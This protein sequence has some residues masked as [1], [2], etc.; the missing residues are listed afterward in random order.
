[1]TSEQDHYIKQFESEVRKR[2]E[3]PDLNWKESNS[4]ESRGALF[5]DFQGVTLMVYPSNGLISIPAVRTYHPPKYPTPVIA[6]ASAKDLW[7]R[8]K[9][10][11]DGN[12]DLARSRTTGHLGPIVD[13]DL[14]CRNPKCPCQDE[15]PQARKGRARGGLNTNPDKC[16]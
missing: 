16:S 15:N 12:L 14:K 8:Q 4:P 3:N 10:R 9:R 2:G 11:D 7:A 6:A 13:P 1:M 5:G